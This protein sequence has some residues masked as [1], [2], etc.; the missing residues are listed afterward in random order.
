[1][2]E[3]DT[4]RTTASPTTASV[5]ALGVLGGATGFDVH[6]VAARATMTPHITTFL[7]SGVM[8]KCYFART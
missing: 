1:L 6:A 7:M 3:T 8:V 5:W 4:L 2:E